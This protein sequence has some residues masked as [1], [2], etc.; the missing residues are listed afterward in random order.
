MVGYLNVGKSVLINRLV[1]KAACASAS[2][3]GVT[4][5]LRWVCIGGDL[6]F[7]DVLGVLLVCMYD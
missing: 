1:G 2:R 6:D 7:L 3:S 4:R 5:D